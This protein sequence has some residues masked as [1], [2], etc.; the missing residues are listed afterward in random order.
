MRNKKWVTLKVDRNVPFPSANP[1]QRLGDFT[2][3]LDN[4]R[5]IRIA[6]NRRR[7]HRHRHLVHCNERSTIYFV[8]KVSRGHVLDT[9]VVS[10]MTINIRIPRHRYSSIRNYPL[11]FFRVSISD[12]VIAKPSP[13]VSAFVST[14][15][16]PIYASTAPT[17]FDSSAGTLGDNETA[18][19]LTTPGGSKQQP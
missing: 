4:R 6:I 8:A 12:E 14:P 1:R 10:S 5:I 18:S 2:R 13:H 9:F 16:S 17:V 15:G 19:N 11:P 7:H 3:H